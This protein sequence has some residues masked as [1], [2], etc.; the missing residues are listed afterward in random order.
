MTERFTMYADGASRGNPGPAAIGAVIYPPGAHEPV[1]EVS[2]AIG[3]ATNNQAEYLAVVAGLE[4]ALDLGVRDL[5]VR[6]DSQLLVR[7]V[8]G[9]YRV[10]NAGLKPLHSRVVTLLGR[11]RSAAFEHVPRE[12]NTVA[13]ALANAALDR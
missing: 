13:D 5:L 4:L 10:R 11:F 1:A 8:A 6:L 3:E 7:Q 9:E 12:R 2:E